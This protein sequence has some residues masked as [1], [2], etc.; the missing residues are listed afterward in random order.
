MQAGRAVKLCGRASAVADVS[1]HVNA[2]RC[3]F[4]KRISLLGEFYPAWI[5]PQACGS[6]PVTTGL[7]LISVRLAAMSE[8][9]LI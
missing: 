8:A 6:L 4:A 9:G 5:V 3:C 1:T 2:L 7:V